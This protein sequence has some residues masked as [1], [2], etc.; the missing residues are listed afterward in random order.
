MLKGHAKIEL[1]DVNT[2]KVEMY[3]EDN[4]V[5]N[6]VAR[7]LNLLRNVNAMGTGEGKLNQ[8]KLLPIYNHM[9]NGILLFQSELEEDVNNMVLPAPAT[10]PL[11]GYASNG[12]YSG[13]DTKRGGMNINESGA[14]E[15]GYKYVWDFATSQANG[16]ISALALTSYMAGATP[17]RNT[18]VSSTV[19]DNYMGYIKKNADITEHINMIEFDFDTGISKQL[20][21]SDATTLLIREIDWHLLNVGLMDAPGKASVKSSITVDLTSETISI[22]AESQWI[23]GEDGYYYALYCSYGQTVN[24]AR[25]NKETLALD[26]EFG[27]K[28]ITLT[29]AVSVQAKEYENARVLNGYLYIAYNNRI[30]KINMNDFSDISYANQS[31]YSVSNNKCMRKWGKDKL[32]MGGLVI[33]EDLSVEKFANNEYGISCAYYRLHGKSVA[34]DDSGAVYYF[35]VQDTD[36]AIQIE[37]NS[38]YNYLATINNLATPVTKTAAQTMKITYTLTEVNG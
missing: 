32:V 16:Q 26:E 18:G 31:Y 3:E 15:N 24:V 1:T 35:Y 13:T 30:H 10:N 14:V 8:S 37:A 6:A 4:L 7:H 38:N 12:A 19:Q 28:T 34:I 25:V 21:M 27:Q 33:F 23:D 2:G 22:N 11:V 5:T 36:T 9:T 20:Y 29:S 17:Y